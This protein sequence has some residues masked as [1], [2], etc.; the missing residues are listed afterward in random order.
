M[1]KKKKER[2]KTEEI[3]KINKNMWIKSSTKKRDNYEFQL[4][5]FKNKL[6]LN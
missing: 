1:F 5:L 4:K 6:K 3:V 2:N